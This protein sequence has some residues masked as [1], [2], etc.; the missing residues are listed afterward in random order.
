MTHR[1]L[2]RL[3][4]LL[5]LREVDPAWRAL[6]DR[7][8]LQADAELHDSA[9]YQQTG[10]DTGNGWQRQ[11]NGG[12]WGADWFGRAQAAVIYIFVNDYH[13]AVY[14]IRGTDANSALCTA[15]TATR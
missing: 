4:A 7:V 13:E 6:L 8:A 15:A 3:R 2:S 14:F 5:A 1:W 11:E 12:A 10:V 9:K